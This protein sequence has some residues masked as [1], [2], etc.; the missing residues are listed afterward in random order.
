MITNKN[1]FLNDPLRAIV[2]LDSNQIFKKIK[3]LNNF[4]I[5][6]EKE[7]I[8]VQLKLLKKIIEKNKNTEYGKKYNF[9]KINDYDD[10][11]KNV[12][13]IKYPD[14]KN[15]I[16]KIKEGKENILTNEKVIY[17]AITSGTTSE[18]KFI[19]ITKKRIKFFIKQILMWGRYVARRN[20]STLKG[21]TLYFAGNDICGYT[22][23]GIP[24][25]NISGYIVKNLPWYAK[26]RLALPSEI[27]R[28][29]DFDSRTKMIALI[30]LQKDISQILF[31]EPIEAIL[32][33]DYLK[34]NKE[35]LIRDLIILGKKKVANN[36]KNK[37]FIPSE[38]WPHLT[39]VNC[40]KTHMNGIYINKLKEKLGNQNIK[41]RD[42]GIYSSES[43][44]TLCIFDDDPSGI[45]LYNT[46]F[47]EFLDIDNNEIKTID[48]LEINKEYMLIITTQEGLYRYNIEDILK[49]TGFKNKIPTLKFIHRNK[50]IDLAGE[51]SPEIE[52]IKAMKYA[53]KI[54]KIK[55]KSFTIIPE[56]DNLEKK[57]KYNI[58]LEL[59]TNIND[60]T[61]K[62]FLYE[63]DLKLQKTVLDYGNM[64]NEYGRIDKPI[65]SILK[66]GSYDNFE[67]KR[68][69]TTGQP[70]IIN[71]SKDP[72]FK[73]NFSIEKRI[74]Y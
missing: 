55:F 1:K 35:N 13:I 46:S 69:I 8:Q 18:A 67:K 38:I 65:L 47:F 66:K 6:S 12:P 23:K 29:D 22:K 36:L 7:P 17:F 50:F 70:K 43:P 42:P 68:V 60:K 53:L 56:L 41:I 52:L 15:F 64:R 24:Y 58:L 63:F 19:P 61:A 49:V 28:I 51:K 25:G 39:T 11:K 32:F 54:K 26:K 3:S 71:V 62:E 37:N 4:E 73:E 40:I 27:Y 59:I 20:I 21:K 16:E 34:N 72:N 45:P 74:S 48:K 31:A 9:K 33:F 2:K 5:F 14:I 57:P 30:S 10:F 44:I